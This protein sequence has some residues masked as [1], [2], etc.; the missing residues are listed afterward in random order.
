MTII[1]KESCMCNYN[2]CLGF[3]NSFVTSMGSSSV[4]FLVLQ[5]H[6]IAQRLGSRRLEC[7]IVIIINFLDSCTLILHSEIH[8]RDHWPI[9]S[10]Q[11]AIISTLIID[12]TII[13]IALFHIS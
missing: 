3:L 13:M 2:T 6:I 5:K 1:S 9:V 10:C 8:N 12:E 4:V 11:L 7:Y